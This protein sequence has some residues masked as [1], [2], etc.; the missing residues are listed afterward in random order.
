MTWCS[1]GR[2]AETLALIRDENARELARD[3]LLN[4]FFRMDVFVREGRPM[5]EDERQKRLL[6]STFMLACPSAE[7]DYEVATPVGRFTFDTPPARAIVACLAAG[8]MSL[9]EVAA[10][11]GFE[12]QAILD[13]AL[14]LCALDVLRPVERDQIDVQRVN[15]AMRRRLGGAEEIPFLALPCGTM[16]K[17]NDALRGLM[18][19]VGDS[20][21][22]GMVDWRKFLATFGISFASYE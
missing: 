8:P 9:A 15:M 13:G 11:S 7:I 14:V 5:N 19:C 4:Q 21:S 18:R 2:R 17:M 12:S 10:R 16:L 1:R 22:G 6:D 3:F 20:D